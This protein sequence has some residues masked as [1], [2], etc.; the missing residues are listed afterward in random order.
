MSSRIKESFM[1]KLVNY[2]ALPNIPFEAKPK[3]FDYPL[4]RYSKNPIINRNI[5]KVIDRTFN[6][7][8]VAYKGG[9]IGV[10]RGD[11]RDGCPNLFLGKS[12]DGI[13]FEIEE[14]PITFISEKDGKPV[15]TDWQY[16]PRLIE[17]D[18]LY[19]IVWCDFFAGATIAIA[20]TSDFVTFKKID[21]PFLP[22]NRNGVLFPRK[23]NGMYYM[24]SRPSDLG[25]TPFGDL[26]VSASPDLRFWGEHRLV[27][28]HGWNW[29]TSLKIGGGP[30]PI[31]L[32]DG[33]LVFIHG[34]TKTCN[35]FVYSVGAIITDKNDVSKV[36]Y[37]CDDFLLTPS[38]SYEVTGFVPNVVF[39]TSI[40]VDG[41]S[42]RIAMYYGAADSY[43]CL[44]FAYVDEI[45]KYVKEH[46]VK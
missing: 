3:D 26:F 9:F 19:Y 13:S 33:W 1:S 32:D 17:I 24:L 10:F 44:A 46:S 14:K 21:H 16:D 28:Q 11:K 6:S 8:V 15:V 5:N 12:K 4:W 34:V 25:H 45:V 37:K 29:W 36:L 35:G 41:D 20:Y 38:E 2:K 27:L 30:A 42:G 22:N 40:L 43:T 23:I 31:E 39:P 18:G 7:S